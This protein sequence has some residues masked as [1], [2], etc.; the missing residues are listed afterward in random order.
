MSGEQIE[1]RSESF[2]S[3]FGAVRPFIAFSRTR[4]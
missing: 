2:P 1:A 4:T 3:I